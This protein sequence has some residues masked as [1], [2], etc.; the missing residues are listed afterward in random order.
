MNYESRQIEC[1]SVNASAIASHAN[2]V[3]IWLKKKGLSTPN[4]F[5][6]GSSQV[7][8]EYMGT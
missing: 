1:D 4:A 8:V 3:N 6:K 2:I 5:V 7:L